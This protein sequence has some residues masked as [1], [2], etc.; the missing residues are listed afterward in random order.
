[1]KVRAVLFSAGA[2][3]PNL[4]QTVVYRFHKRIRS[5]KAGGGAIARVIVGGYSR[6]SYL[7]KSGASIH[8]CL[9]PVSNDSNHVPVLREIVLIGQTSVARNNHR[10]AILVMLIT[11]LFEDI[12]ER[13]DLPLDRAAV[14][15]INERISGRIE[16]IAG[17]DHV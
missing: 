17:G 7:I 6:G 11:G 15:D 2:R 16:N 9:N 3:R 1:M 14:L 8:H 5:P 13:V 12:V 10:A 4:L